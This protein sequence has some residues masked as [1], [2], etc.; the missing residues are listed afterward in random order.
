V[1]SW[2][3]RSQSLRWE[4]KRNNTALRANKK[5]GR[6]HF[7]EWRSPPSFFLLSSCGGATWSVDTQKGTQRALKTGKSPRT[8]VDSPHRQNY[9]APPAFQRCQMYF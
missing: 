9:L 1:A 3:Q 4:Q 8:H 6:R 5:K 2:N 7:G